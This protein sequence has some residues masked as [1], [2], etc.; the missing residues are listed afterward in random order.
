MV[1][2]LPEEWSAP[3]R[4][5]FRCPAGHAHIH[6]TEGRRSAYC[7]PCN[8]SYDADAIRDLAEEDGAEATA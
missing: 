3:G 5:R 2:R 7:T 1:E 4:W 6:P 8:E